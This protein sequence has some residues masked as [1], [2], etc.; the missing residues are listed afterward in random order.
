MEGIHHFSLH[1][2]MYKF[3]NKKRPLNVAIAMLYGTS[4]L[5]VIGCFDLRISRKRSPTIQNFQLDW[6]VPLII[7]YQSLWLFLID[8]LSVP[9]LADICNC[10]RKKSPFKCFNDVKDTA[11]YCIMTASSSIFLSY[12]A[13]TKC[14]LVWHCPCQ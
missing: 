14:L 13:E 5:L 4:T 10:L 3:S 12:E 9:H 1:N 11:F 8:C 7:W 2:D 6:I